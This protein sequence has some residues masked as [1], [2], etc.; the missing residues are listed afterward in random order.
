MKREIKGFV[1]GAL[2]TLIIGIGVV[3]ATGAWESIDVLRNDI[4][5]VV[6][7][8]EVVADNFVYNDTTY[9]PLRAVS[10]AL[11]QPVEYDEETNT[12]YI[13]ERED[14]E[15]MQSKYTPSEIYTNDIHIRLTDGVY[16]CVGIDVDYYLYKN[17]GVK[18]EM[19][20]ESNPD[21]FIITNKNGETRSWKLVAID[22]S[23]LT[24]IPYDTFVDEILP[25][26]E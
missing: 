6:N 20:S 1:C 4:T 8:D 21:N 15:I 22:D 5:V 26:V 3:S 14:D 11:S 25:F 17:Y 19:L 10:E 7:G 9:L 12:A 16:Y 23:I 18:A 2:L 24:F 13:G